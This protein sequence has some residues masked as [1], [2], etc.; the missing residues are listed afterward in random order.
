MAHRP[1]QLHISKSAIS[2]S[3][4][5][6]HTPRSTPSPFGLD[7]P[8]AL[9]G[10]IQAAKEP[11]DLFHFPEREHSF[12]F[13]SSLTPHAILPP[14]HS[15]M[16]PDE[17]STGGG[18]LKLKGSKVS[19]GRIE[20]KKKKTGKKKDEPG[21]SVRP[22]E[23]ENEKEKDQDQE[24]DHAQDGAESVEQPPL[25]ES[26]ESGASAAKTETERKYEEVRRKRVCVHWPIR[27]SYRRV[28][29]DVV[30]SYMSDSSARVPRRT[31]SAWKS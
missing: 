21:P 11:R 6:N 24:R 7:A 2:P 9:T 18:K 29:A 25:N 22:D 28:N 8:S 15:L 16:A 10:L 3:G 31:R 5:L 1:L 13:P 17:Y 27:G 4:A 12:P 14:P 20:K 19:G 26:E 23:R 30:S